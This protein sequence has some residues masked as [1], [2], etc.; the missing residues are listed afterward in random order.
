MILTPENRI[1]EYTDNGWWN[2]DTL[3][4]FLD[5]CEEAG[6]KEALLDPPNRKEFTIGD[7][8]RLTLMRLKRKLIS[9]PQSFL[10]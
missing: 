8:R 10:I 5:A 1:K 3:Y 2:S 6:N 7:S 9:F 4:T